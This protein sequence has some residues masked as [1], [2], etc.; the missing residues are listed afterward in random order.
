MDFSTPV[1]SVQVAFAGGSFFDDGIGRLRA[2]DAGNNLIGEYITAPRP[3]GSPEVMSITRPQADIAWASAFSLPDEG[4]FGRLDDLRFATAT[5]R[6]AGDT[7]CDGTVNFFDIDPFVVAIL[8]P[9]LYDDLYPDCDMLT[10][11]V[12]DDGLVNFFDIDPFLA[13]LFP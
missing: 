4:D 13:V 3:E 7:N 6:P 8:T 10:A 2:Y 5:P 9:E 11:D 1:S 12:N